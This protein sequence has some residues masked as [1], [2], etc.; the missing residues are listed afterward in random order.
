MLATMSSRTIQMSDALCDY[1]RGAALREPEP[2][3]RLRA[4]TAGLPDARMQI[5]PE[6]GQLMMLLVEMLGCRRALELGTYTG[7]SSLCVALAMPDDGRLIACEVSAEWTAVARRYWR[8]AGVEH[9]IDLR[10]APA[11]QTLNALLADGQTG[12]FDFAFIDADKTRCD[13]YFERCLALLR[14]GGLIAV[15]NAFRGGR[16]AD[17]AVTDPDTAAIRALNLKVR[18]DPRVTSSLIP[19]GDGLLLARKRG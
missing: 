16:V 5:S 1:L 10:L 14:P 6:Q 11:E 18:D 2:L 8:L 17:A 7:Y 13:V 15:D 12:R 9:K 4:E 3:V 19:I